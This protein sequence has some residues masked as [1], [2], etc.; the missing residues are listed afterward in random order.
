MPGSTKAIAP[1]FD[2][3]LSNL[4]TLQW[5]VGIPGLQEFRGPPLK[6]NTYCRGKR[7]YFP[8]QVQA[9]PVGKTLNPGKYRLTPPGVFAHEPFLLAPL[10]Y[11]VK[12]LSHLQIEQ[13]VSKPIAPH[14]S[15][16]SLLLIK[17]PGKLLP[18]RPYVMHALLYFLLISI[19]L[20]FKFP[21][22]R[23]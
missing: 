6:T 10:A 5:G 11:N 18:A 12:K 17:H 13:V 19:L 4:W 1:N 20:P 3:W 21:K 23:K 7:G 2:Q 14:C 9:H 8:P 15:A 16:P 22:T